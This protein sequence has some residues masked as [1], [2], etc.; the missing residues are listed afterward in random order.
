MSYRELSPQAY[1]AEYQ[2]KAAEDYVLID[3][4]RPDEYASGHIEGAILMNVEDPAFPEQVAKLDPNQT[5]YVN[6]RS[7]ARSGR[8]CQY[9][10][11][12]GF[13]HTINLK[14]GMLAWQDAKLPVKSGSEA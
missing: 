3:V 1:L 13:G 11:S 12:Q 9:M 6:C 4:R 14:G 2:G 7:G 10:A 5:Y 8:A